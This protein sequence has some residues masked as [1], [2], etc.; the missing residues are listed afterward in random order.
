MIIFTTWKQ[1]YLYYWMESLLKASIANHDLWLICLFNVNGE[2]GTVSRLKN[3]HVDKQSC[4]NCAVNAEY[5]KNW[6]T[7]VIFWRRRL[8]KERFWKKSVDG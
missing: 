6:A 3:I 7:L 8:A 4:D 2:A 1:N 5:T